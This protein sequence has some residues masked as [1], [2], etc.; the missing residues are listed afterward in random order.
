[1][2]GSTNCF[3]TPTKKE[4]RETM[5]RKSIRHF[6]AACLLFAFAITAVSA[7]DLV[8]DVKNP[9]K[10]GKKDFAAGKYKISTGSGAMDRSLVIRNMNT[11]TDTVVPF[12]TRFSARDESRG[13][14][15]FDSA[16]GEFFLAEV[17][18]PNEDGIHLQGAPGS[19]SH[20]KTPASESK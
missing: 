11:S 20:V 1:M 19:H 12:I 2:C 10:V 17:Y 5:I 14:L 7:A 9:F 13:S 15:V 6:L 3:Q 8:V 18:F 4:D 16:N